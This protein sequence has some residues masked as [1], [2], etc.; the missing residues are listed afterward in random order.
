MKLEDYEEPV[1]SP[2]GSTGDNE[3]EQGSPRTPTLASMKENRKGEELK[4]SN[5]SSSS[6]NPIKPN[7]KKVDT[8]KLSRQD[9][10]TFSSVS[11]QNSK[12]N[13]SVKFEERTKE[14]SQKKSKQQQMSSDP[15]FN[16]SI[17]SN[18]KGTMLTGS[19]S[20]ARL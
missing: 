19:I 15:P 20:V 5:K 18:N 12:G 7:L 6:Y 11:P 13:K 3:L 9:S 16:R 8:S 14:S 2:V 10:A 17:N 1:W 4:Y